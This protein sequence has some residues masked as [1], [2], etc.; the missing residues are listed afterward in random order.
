MEYIN[1]DK[2][3]AFQELKGMTRKSVKELLTKDRI[4]KA[5]IKLG[6]GLTY[7]YAAMNVSD[8]V[9]SKAA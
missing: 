6:G 8:E 2:S 3:K 7:N 1:L 9:S 4:E 5:G